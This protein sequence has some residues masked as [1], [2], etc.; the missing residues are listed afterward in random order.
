MKKINWKDIDAVIF[1][2]DGVLTDS[3]P[4]INA[5]GIKALEDFGVNAKPED[6]HPFVGAGDVRYIG[7]VA[8]KYGLVY[9]PEM[10]ARMY[11]IYFELLPAMIKSFPGVKEI[12]KTLKKLNK[13]IAVAS[14]ADRVKVEGNLKAIGLDLS[15]FDAILAA[16][17]VS[18]KKPDPEIFI[19]AG[20]KVGVPAGRC[21]VVEDALNGVQAAKAAGMKCVAVTTSFPVEKL[22]QKEPDTV[23]PDLLELQKQ[24]L[25]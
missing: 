7:G 15:V 22:L 2:M 14:A 16:E 6:F 9:K 12:L 24:V 3:E 1:D 19:K 13:K 17:D 4:I 11:E 21:C 8:E 18:K 23:V 10:K 5:A 25:A 20:Q